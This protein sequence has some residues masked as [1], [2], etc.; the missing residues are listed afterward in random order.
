MKERMHSVLK[1]VITVAIVIM[2]HFVTVNSVQATTLPTGYSQMIGID[3]GV[4]VPSENGGQAIYH[5]YGSSSWDVF[6]G[7]YYYQQ[8][9]AEE[10]LFYDRLYNSCLAYLTT[11]KNADA[12]ATNYYR[13]E[14]VSCGTLNS[15][16]MTAVGLIFQFSNPQFYFINDMY[17]Y[18]YSANQYSYAFGVYSDFANGATRSN[19]T[20]TIKNKL[21]GWMTEID[22]ESDVVAKE[23]KA[24]DLVVSNTVYSSSSKY[25]QSS[26]SVLLEG[27][28][29]CAGYA[30]TFGM[31]CNAAG[32][33]TICVTSNSHEWNEVKLYGRWYA[34]DCTW[35]DQQSISYSYFNVSDVT[36]RENNNAHALQAFWSSY[37]VPAC[38]NNTVITTEAVVTPTPT[39]VSPTQYVLNGVN[40][41]SVF[42]AD[43]YIAKYAD[44]RA[45]YGSNEEKALEHFVNYGMAEG[46]QGCV[47]FSVKAYR[48]K[49]V[50]LRQ[51]YGYDFKSYYFHYMNYGENEGR[52]SGTSEV[53]INGI[54][55]WNGVDYS[56]VYNYKYYVGR[57]RD[58]ANAYGNDDYAVLAHFVNYGMAEGRQGKDSFDV[59]SYY[60]AYPDLRSA[61]GKDMKQYYLHYMYYGRAEGRCS[62]GVTSLNGYVTIYN[63]VN[64]AAVYDYNDYISR[65]ADIKAAYGNDDQA[66]LA[67]FVKYGMAEGRQGSA[68]FNVRNYMNKYKDLQNTY[69]SDLTAYYNHY[70][71]FGMNEGRVAR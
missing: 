44:I 64:Y 28:T 48:A 7:N 56:A 6:G 13:T 17:Y 2:V 43:Y 31:L 21:D 20:T 35:D 69:G 18:G 1:L 61:Y 3:V 60:N 25:N 36:I 19:Y 8:L 41:T 57:Y 29:V 4:A 34:V 23:K 51:I 27:K 66:V 12:Y 14:Y 45:A 5:T 55:V 59:A 68:N 67:H 26:A 58:I 46:R 40:Y 53:I 10:K 52:T 16:Q 49:Y 71:V 15:D 30:E 24:H 33:Q 63:G 32:I 47:S 22:R 50:D 38:T 62:V 39:P 11:Q 9:S 37:N 65:Y 54:T 70:I 42:D